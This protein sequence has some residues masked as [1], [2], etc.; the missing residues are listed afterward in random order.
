MIGN[1]NRDISTRDLPSLLDV[2][3]F[4]SMFHEHI[5]S[6][7]V[8]NSKDLIGF[9]SGRS[10]VEGGSLKFRKSGSEVRG[11]KRK[12]PSPFVVQSAQDNSEIRRFSIPQRR[13]R[14]P[15]LSNESFKGYKNNGRNSS[16]SSYPGVKINFLPTRRPI[17][18]KSCPKSIHRVDG[19]D[20]CTSDRLDSRLS[21]VP[22]I[23]SFIAVRQPSSTLVEG[24]KE[25]NF[26]SDWCA[27]VVERN[28][29]LKR[30]KIPRNGAIRAPRSFHHVA[31]LSTKRARFQQRF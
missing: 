13:T 31:P 21:I 29:S 27:S 16:F 6:L 24:K 23:V 4:L 12:L 9:P 10:S 8:T 2:K 7:A 22:F 17:R 5:R 20:D 30:Y 25:G 1:R 3:V 11:E 18:S 28:D 26:S 14:G 15:L 19:G